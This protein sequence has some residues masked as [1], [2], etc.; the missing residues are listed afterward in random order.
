LPKNYQPKDSKHQ[1]P[2]S[3][4]PRPAYS[5]DDAKDIMDVFENA[6]R[7]GGGRHPGGRDAKP[8]SIGDSA[9]I[10]S[11]ATQIKPRL[12]SDRDQKAAR[13]ARDTS[14]NWR[15]SVFQIT[16]ATQ[17]SLACSLGA[18]ERRQFLL[19]QKYS[20]DRDANPL[21]HGARNRG[22]QN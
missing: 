20:Q 22:A 1:S 2:A 12:S 13:S 7:T 15:R 6:V 11:T 8:S 17:S 9:G 10:G 5:I 21:T 3:K 16:S 19:I 14:S 4:A 18:S